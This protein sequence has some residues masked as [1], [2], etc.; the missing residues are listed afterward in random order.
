[1]NTEWV[2]HSNQKE[3]FEP[4][5]VHEEILN[6]LIVSPGIVVHTVVENH[7]GTGVNLTLFTHGKVLLDFVHDQ[8]LT[9]TKVCEDYWTELSM[10]EERWN[11]LTIETIRLLCTANYSTEG[12]ILVVVQEVTNKGTLTRTTTPNKNC[13]GILRNLLHLELAEGYIHSGCCCHSV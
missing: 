10:N 7:K 12:H 3:D 2:L 8:F 1:L 9:F 5:T 4:T 6:V 13:D 11:H